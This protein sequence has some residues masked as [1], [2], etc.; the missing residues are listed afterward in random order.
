[1][2][3]SGSLKPAAELI[4]EKA[5]IPSIVTENTIINLFM[6]SPLNKEKGLNDIAII[7]IL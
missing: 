2:S 6:H 1:V 3:W 4:E 5:A 7:G